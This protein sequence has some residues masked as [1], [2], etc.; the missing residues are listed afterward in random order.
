MRKLAI[1]I[2]FCFFALAAVFGQNAPK[3]TPP[4]V[5]PLPTYAL[6]PEEKAKLDK[7]A[8]EY[9]KADEQWRNSKKALEESAVFQSFRAAD[10]IRGGIAT[11][12]DNERLRLCGEAGIKP[13]ECDLLPDRSGLVRKPLEPKKTP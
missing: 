9:E 6:K 8:D 4:E 5:K 1:T 2:C 3:A 12:F 13:S 7:L 10:A 11:T